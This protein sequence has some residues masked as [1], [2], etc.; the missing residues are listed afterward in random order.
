MKTNVTNQ[1]I[2]NLR[3]KSSIIGGLW[4]PD[5][6]VA[7]FRTALIIP[8]NNNELYNSYYTT[9]IFHIHTFLRR[10]KLNYGVYFVTT[11]PNNKELKFNKGI[12]S[13]AGFNEAIKDQDYDCFIFHDV[14]M[15]PLNEQ[16]IYECNSEYPIR[17][18]SYSS[19]K[20]SK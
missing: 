16:N 15:V 11:D 19:F 6:C 13:N 9:F 14:D 4:K 7:K 1:D 2:N 17:F 3:D 8:I 10:Q 20:F 12:L 18:A 5:D